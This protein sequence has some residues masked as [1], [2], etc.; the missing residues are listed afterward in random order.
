MS[1]HNHTSRQLTESFASDMS[2]G[3]EIAGFSF[4]PAMPNPM[5]WNHQMEID[6]T[7]QYSYRQGS[8]PPT[9]HSLNVSFANNV[10]VVPDLYMEEAKQPQ[11]E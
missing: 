7:A 11:S 10:E 2:R 4:P 5:G 8:V 3:P 6:A 9:Q 1:R